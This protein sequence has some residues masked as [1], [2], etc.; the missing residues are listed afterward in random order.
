MTTVVAMLALG[1]ICWVFRVL[2]IVLVPADRLPSRVRD[3]LVHLA[4]AVLAALVAV[5]LDAVVRAD[6]PGAGALVLASALVVGIAARVTRSLT[7]AIGLG[8]G[9]ALLLDLVVLA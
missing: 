6:T 9:A 8:L 4:P 3:G 5:E 1:A 2:L 7:L